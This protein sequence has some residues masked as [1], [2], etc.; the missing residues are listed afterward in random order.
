MF[1]SCEEEDHND[2]CVPESF[3]W[4]LGFQVANEGG[5]IR[6]HIAAPGSRNAFYPGERVVVYNRT[7]FDVTL[8]FTFPHARNH[9]VLPR[10]M[11]VRYD[12]DN[13]GWAST[14]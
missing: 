13:G 9:R 14:N 7:T 4:G 11:L 6:Q 8:S 3:L 12:V 5:I 10:W 2:L 1:D